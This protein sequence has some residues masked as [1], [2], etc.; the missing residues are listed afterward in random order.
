MS[1]N[2]RIVIYSSPFCGFCSAAKRLL[3]GKGA[4]YTEIDTLADKTR[5]DEMIERTARRTVPQIFI[6]ERHIGGYDELHALDVRGE[7]DALLAGV[8]K[9]AD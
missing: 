5:R 6:G 3:D 7:L 2:A 9:P 1:E 4:E 8:E